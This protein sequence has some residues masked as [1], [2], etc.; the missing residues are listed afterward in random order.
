[1][2]VLLLKICC[3]SALQSTAC[4]VAVPFTSLRSQK[5][6]S[7]ETLIVLPSHVEPMCPIP[8]TLK[9]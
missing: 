2:L 8:D 6:K 7:E 1:M 4:N 3:L 9:S 5:D